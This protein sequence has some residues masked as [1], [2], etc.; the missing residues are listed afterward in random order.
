MSENTTNISSAAKL[1]EEFMGAEG[2]V[3]AEIITDTKENYET[4]DVINFMPVAEIS[5]SVQKETTTKYYDNRAWRII[6]AEGDDTIKLTVPALPAVVAAYLEDKTVD[7]ETGAVLDDG[8]GR[9]KYFA[10]GYKVGLSDGTFRYVWRLKGSFVQGEEKAKT[11]E[12]SKAESNGMELTYTG[13]ATIHEFKYPDNKERPAKSIFLDER[14]G[15]ADVSCF[16][17]EVITPE[18]IEN[19]KKNVPVNS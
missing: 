7:T 5:K 4:G 16:F 15:K 9:I 17:E 18:T 6:V 14:D 12:G 8:V 10:L 2:L 11:K 3:I 13:L 19:I 1:S